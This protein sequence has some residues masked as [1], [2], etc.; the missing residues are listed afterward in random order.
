MQH[1]HR[2]HEA[3]RKVIKKVRKGPCYPKD[4]YSDKSLDLSRRTVQHDLELGK[5]LGIFRKLEDK[6]YAWIDYVEKH[7][8][9]REILEDFR[10]LYCRWPHPKEVAADFGST[11]DEVEKVIYEV[12]GS[13]P[14]E[15]RWREP[16]EEDVQTAESRAYKRLKLAAFIK[17]GYQAS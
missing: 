7:D 6:R 11:P 3:F 2:R 17:F 5:Y 1:K 4:I 13:Q 8:R 12:A 14:E 16:T 15:N 10:L 9:M